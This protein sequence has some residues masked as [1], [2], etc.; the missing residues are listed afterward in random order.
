MERDGLWHAL[1]IP[2]GVTLEA[3]LAQGPGETRR[4]ADGAV[5]P[6]PGAVPVAPLR[7]G[8][9]VAIG[10][11][12]LD[13]I[14]ETGM[15]KPARP[16]MFAKFPSSVIGPGEPIVIDSGLTGSVDWEVE[17]AAVVGTPLRHAGPAEALAAVAGYTVANDVSARDLQFS[18][19]QWTR[20]KSLDTFCPLGPVVVTPDELG[21]P[22]GLRLR[23]VVNGETVQD[24][25]TAE[26]LFGVA[27][28]LSFCS[29]SFTLEPGDVV[30]TGTPWGCGAF[31][32]PPRSLSPG[33]VVEVSVEG[34]GELRNP[35]VDGTR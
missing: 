10:L 23:T 5:G 24:S 25:S 26:M 19:G 3:L 4:A 29:A 30:L 34:I 15:D 18:D 16:L 6:L 28:L 27:E 8:K 20:G 31:M 11:N 17:L 35:V 13:H 14:R 2:A 21:D 12:Y 1:D 33:D 22:Q 9:I 32:D 7:P